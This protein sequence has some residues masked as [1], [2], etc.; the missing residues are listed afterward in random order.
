MTAK[1]TF[2]SDTEGFRS[3]RG[4]V[5]TVSLLILLVMTIIGVASMGSTT[6][7][8]KMSN[9]N[10]QSQIA[11]Q[12]AEVA[13]R[14]GEAY[15]VA[16][17]SSVNDLATNFNAT[18]PVTGLYSERAPLVGVATRPLPANTNIFDD[19]G[20]LATGNAIPVTTTMSGLTQQPRFIIEYMGRVGEPPKTGY[21][22]KKPDTRQ[23]AFRITAIGWGEGTNPTARYILQSSFRMPLL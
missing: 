8:E 4:A 5:L 3:Q 18:A 10:R 11:L 12:A 7:Q 19:T 17:I 22:N 2:L 6:L 23:Y 15:L 13:L 1:Q 20:W 21:V 9:N 14:N 16:N